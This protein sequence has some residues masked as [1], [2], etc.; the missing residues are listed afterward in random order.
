MNTEKKKIQLV[1]LS[2]GEEFSLPSEFGDRIFTVTEWDSSGGMRIDEVYW[3]NPSTM[4]FIDEKYME[5][6]VKIKE[7][8]WEKIPKE[9][10]A[11]MWDEED[12]LVHINVDCKV[13]AFGVDGFISDKLEQTT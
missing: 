8:D 6:A 7:S 1:E 4:V 13:I 10:L 11:K 2:K 5:I 3:Q 12:N 9:Q